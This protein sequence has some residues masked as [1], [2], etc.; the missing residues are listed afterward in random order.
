MKEK[1][2]K[3]WSVV[4]STSYSRMGPS[5]PSHRNDLCKKTSRRLLETI[6]V[7]SEILS[8]GWEK[9][10]ISTMDNHQSSTWNEFRPF[11]KKFRARWKHD[12]TGRPSSTDQVPPYTSLICIKTHTHETYT[13]VKMQVSNYLPVRTKRIRTSG[14]NGYEHQT[15]SCQLEK[16]VKDQENRSDQKIDDHVKC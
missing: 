9:R 1:A 16:E 6:W 3:T 7:H 8:V 12:C 10:H 13:F 14:R 4:T 11:T 15:Q 5:L 2:E